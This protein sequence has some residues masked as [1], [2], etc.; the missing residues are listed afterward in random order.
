[1]EDPRRWDEVTSD[2]VVAISFFLCSYAPLFAILAIRFRTTWLEL[3]CAAL[4]ALGLAVIARYRARLPQRTS[5]T[6][7]WSRTAGAEVAA[8]HSRGPISDLAAP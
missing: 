8:R 1:M 3:T 4:A 6:T 7:N 2:L 5:S